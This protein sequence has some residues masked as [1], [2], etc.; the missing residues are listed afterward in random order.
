MDIQKGTVIWITGLPCSGKTTISNK[1]NSL[2]SQKNLFAYT[3]DGDQI[4][5]GLNSDLGFSKEDRIENI[6]RVGEVSKLFADAGFII[7]VAL[8]SPFKKDR[9]LV[10]SNLLPGQFVEVYLD[11]P[12]EECEKRDVKGHYKLARNGKMPGFTGISS[13]YEPPLN[14]E[15][16]L[17]THLRNSSE[18]V[19]AII[20]HLT[21][22]ERM[23]L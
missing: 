4:R 14:P 19:N 17:K 3:L 12:L 1:L 10:R 22:F 18:C 20:N 7:I 8:I 2:L 11:C 9:D 23:T 21:K 13:P 5:K 6:R 15:L 16:K